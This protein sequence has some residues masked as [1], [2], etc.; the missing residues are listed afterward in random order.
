MPPKL[1][2]TSPLANVRLSVSVMNAGSSPRYCAHA[3][4]SPRAPRISI[5]FDMCLSCR[6]PDRI[7][8][9]MTIAPN[10]IALAVDVRLELL[11]R[12]LLVGDH[13]LHQIADRDQTE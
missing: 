3:S 7:S 1:T 9:P 13:L 12:L 11:D 4:S 2:T 6:L 8:S 10:R 5:A